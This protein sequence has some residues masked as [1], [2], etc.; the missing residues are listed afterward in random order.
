MEDALD[1]WPFSVE[2]QS[3]FKGLSI[4]QSDV[5][6]Y[7]EQCGDAHDVEIERPA[8]LVVRLPDQLAAERFQST[9]GGVMTRL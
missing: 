2:I 8:T 7:F 4:L 1:T 6:A 3:D 9:F 5:Q